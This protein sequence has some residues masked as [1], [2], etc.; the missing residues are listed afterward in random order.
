MTKRILIFD[1]TDHA[2]L[3]DQ[4]IR[5]K[6]GNDHFI[7]AWSTDDLDQFL[8][9]LQEHRHELDLLL[10]DKSSSLGKAEYIVKYFRKKNERASIFFFTSWSENDE[11]IKMKREKFITA[12]YTKP[13]DSKKLYQGLKIVFEQK[14]TDETTYDNVN[15]DLVHE[16]VYDKYSQSE[17]LSEDIN[18]VD[19]SIS[20]EKHE[21]NLLATTDEE[22]A[23]I[24]K[25]TFT[26]KERKKYSGNN[27][28]VKFSERLLTFLI[29]LGSIILF[30]VIGIAVIFLITF[31]VKGGVWLSAL[32]LPWVAPIIW[33][34]FVINVIMLPIAFFRTSRP[35]YGY[36]L[37]ISSYVY[38]ITLWTWAFLIS[39]AIWGF[40]GII[41]GLIFLGIGVVPIA[42][43]GSM[44]EGEWST[45]LQLIVFAVIWLVSRS[46]GIAFIEDKEDSFNF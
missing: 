1:N 30:I 28:F 20:V 26:E 13:C 35:F 34:V 5:S 22:L 19:G 7:L 10:V 23:E 39:Y 21:D 14:I 31:L 4:F 46:L 9:L 40:L 29:G 36:A 2:R 18:E 33:F 27:W 16:S 37:Y 15:H 44:V 11:L 32:I 38:G 17:N 41:I 42:I 6:F 24:Y 43:I 25:R 3:I 8:F 12:I 45:V